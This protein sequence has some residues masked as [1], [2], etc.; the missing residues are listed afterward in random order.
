MLPANDFCLNKTLRIIWDNSDRDELVNSIS[1][2]KKHVC[3]CHLL[4]VRLIRL[5]VSHCRRGGEGRGG[6]RRMF[7]VLFEWEKKIFFLIAG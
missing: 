4:I 7:V 2:K 3:S 5:D 6:R 1:M